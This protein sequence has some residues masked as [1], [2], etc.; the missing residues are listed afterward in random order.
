MII[1]LDFIMLF[2][3]VMQ[4]HFMPVN[5]NMVRPP[6]KIVQPQHIWLCLGIVIRELGVR[7]AL[8]ERGW[9]LPVVGV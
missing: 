1:N 5:Q 3:H 4:E 8:P 9:W 2:I 6:R 7:Y